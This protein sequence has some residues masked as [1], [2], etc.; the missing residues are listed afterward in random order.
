MTFK[1]RFI[2]LLALTG[3]AL[4]LVSCA[5]AKQQDRTIFLTTGLSEGEVFII[6][7]VSRNISNTCTLPEA[8]VYLTDT[9][10]KYE[11]VYGKGI[12]RW[13]MFQCRRA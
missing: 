3:A 2:S 5:K 11:E 13:I 7:D 1:N 8:Y 9:K 10:N 12:P 4:M 6:K